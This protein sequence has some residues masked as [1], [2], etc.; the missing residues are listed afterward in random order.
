MSP[1]HPKR[2]SLKTRRQ[3]RVSPSP[4]LRG[5]SWWARI[6]RLEH[7]AIQRPLGVFGSGNSDVALE[8]CRF[9][10]WCKGRRDAFLLEQIA[11][12][13]VVAGMAYTAYIENRLPAFVTELREGVK[14]VDLEPFVPR[15]QKELERVKKPN[16][17][18]RAKYLRQVRT[19]IPAGEPFRRSVFTKQ[20]IRDWL[21]GLDIGQ[22]NRYRAALSS[23][24]TFL[25]FEDVLATNPVLQVPAAAE[26]DPRTR[27]L[28]QLDAKKLVNAFTDDRIRA[29]HALMLAT[30]MEFGAAQQVDPATVTESS[31]YAGGTKREHRKRTCEIPPRWRWAWAIAR[32]VL[33]HAK[34]G[35][36]PF[37]DISVH[38]SHRRL[39]RA[40]AAA[41]LDP[42][43]TQHD[44]RHTWAVQAVRDGLPLHV[45]AHQLGHRDAVMTLRVYGRFRP[46]GADYAGKG[47]AEGRSES[48]PDANATNTA[49]PPLHSETVE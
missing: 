36:L 7:T 2:S 41:Q 24:A 38:Q 11:T 48:N 44:H 27:Y 23:F 20:R 29:L 43:Y 18:T 35:T 39:K 47:Q 32:P 31:V 5:Q 37:A 45:I 6:P 19:L 9:L 12:G 25:I 34:A 40:L 1:K 46:T 33:E 10:A 30:G 14:D 4:F 17:E 28:V 15:W 22:P 49:T 26:S 8:V 21:S 13:K 3:Q 42:K 16:A